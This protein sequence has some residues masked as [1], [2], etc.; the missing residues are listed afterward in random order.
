MNTV[1]PVRK[2]F[3]LAILALAVVQIAC[4]VGAKAPS[5]SPQQP[6]SSPLPSDQTSSD[7]GASYAGPI[8]LTGAI[9][10]TYSPVR[11]S[12]G[13]FGGQIPVYP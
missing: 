1:F 12:A 3:L 9:N 10:K 6:E 5:T 13:P 8:T 11:I 7:T 2:P 4:A